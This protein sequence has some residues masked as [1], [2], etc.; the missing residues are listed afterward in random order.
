MRYRFAHEEVETVLERRF[1]KDSIKWDDRPLPVTRSN[2]F[3]DP[4]DLIGT[5]SDIRRESDG[6]LTAEIEWN[7]RGELIKDLVNGPDGAY[8]TIYGGD[9]IFGD[10]HESGDRR[11]VKSTKLKAL[12]LAVGEDPWQEKASG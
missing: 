12:F 4:N 7:E 1:E 2:N 8:L 3:G 9:V 5:A 11:N 10:L 6:S